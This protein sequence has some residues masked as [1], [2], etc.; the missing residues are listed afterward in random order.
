MSSTIYEITPLVDVR[1]AG[2]GP[3]VIPIPFISRAYINKIIVVQ[4]DGVFGAFTVELFNRPEIA[5]D[6]G[7][8]SESAGPDRVGIIPEDLFR[9]TP[10]LVASSGGKL[11]HFSEDA[12][13]GRGYAFVGPPIRN[14]FKSQA[15][16]YMRIT[17]AAAGN[18]QYAIAISGEN[19]V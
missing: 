1:I 14:D 6:L 11:L 10:P 7:Q 15:I 16:L 8:T 18:N 17:P 4:T 2:P 13:G 3:Q 5:G 12:N 19:A 9:V